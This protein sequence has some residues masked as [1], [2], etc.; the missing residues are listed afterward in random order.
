MAD[1]IPDPGNL[2]VPAFF[3][4]LTPTSVL[5]SRTSRL[6]VESRS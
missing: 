2:T 4:N 6:V 1:H 3:P 5:A